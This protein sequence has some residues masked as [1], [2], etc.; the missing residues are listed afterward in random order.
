M[1]LFDESPGRKR[2]VFRQIQPHPAFE[3]GNGRDRVRLRDAD[4]RG[5]VRL[6]GGAKGLWIGLADEDFEF[7]SAFSSTPTLRMGGGTEAR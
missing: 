4:G 7:P 3:R 6:L 2:R 1:V 5:V